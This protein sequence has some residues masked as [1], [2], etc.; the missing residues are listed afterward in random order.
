MR[1]VLAPIIERYLALVQGNLLWMALGGTA[2]AALV[3]VAQR[4]P[5]WRALPIAVS[6]VA[7]AIGL[8][9]A[10]AQ[11]SLV[12]D[13]FVSFRYAANLLDG[14]GLVYN[15]GERVEGYTNFLWTVLVA[16]GAA[17]TP[18]SLPHVALILAVASYLA[19]VAL[20]H[21]LG[22]QLSQETAYV[23]IAAMCVAVQATVTSYATTG[24]ETLFA[25]VWIHAMLLAL[26]SV[27]GSRGAAF[28]G[29][30]ATCAVLTRLDHALFYAAGGVALVARDGGLRALWN[31]PA[32][33]RAVVAFCAPASVVVA[34]LG[35]RLWYY[36]DVLPNTFYAKEGGGWRLDQ[37]AIYAVTFL[38]GAHA[39][40]WIAGLAAWWIGGGDTAAARTLRIY[41]TIAVPVW[42]LY[43]L[44]VGGDF[45]YGRFW[46]PLVPSLL[47][48]A[49]RVVL[50]SVARRQL[51]RAVVA[52]FVIGATL[53]GVPLIPNRDHI[54]GIAD[55]G[56]Y[57]PIESLFPLVIDHASYREGTLLG[58]AL[59]DRGITPTIATCCIGMAGY[60]SGLELI[61]THGL[62]DRKVARQKTPERF[63][64]PGHEKIAEKKYILERGVRLARYHAHPKKWWKLT[65]LTFA[66]ERT[67]RWYVIVYDRAL[68][69][70]IA[71]EAPEIGFVDFE[72]WLDRYIAEL[73][74]KDPKEIRG[75]LAFFDSYYFDH[76]EDPGRRAPIAAAAVLEPDVSARR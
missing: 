12:D 49:E 47:L 36:G 32:A 72:A 35:W 46:L 28:A 62:T 61:D 74:S 45:M 64:K 50:R 69:R 58:S 70:R 10:W 7:V 67:S 8:W 16:A 2:L 76:N 56:T 5:E 57:Y 17:L 3:L 1:E 73:T 42:S 65:E 14:K 34:V 23:P 44:K 22:R 71:A 18:I 13:A 54:E 30:A 33:R 6:V 59:R 53:R 75:D 26:A 41:T 25:V 21:R 68:M 4:R 51:A 40:V 15:E 60:Y 11:R 43:V 38:L 55:E 9:F 20:V 63:G 37:G 27:P 66:G 19:L 48:G 24:M 29:L 39:W 31:D 52:A